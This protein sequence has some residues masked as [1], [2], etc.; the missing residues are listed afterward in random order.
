MRECNGQ[1]VLPIL[2]RCHHGL[3]QGCQQEVVLKWPWSEHVWNGEDGTRSKARE[4]RMMRRGAE[5][6]EWKVGESGVE[7]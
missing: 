3:G 1:S 6:L 2:G 7:T 4:S 5:K